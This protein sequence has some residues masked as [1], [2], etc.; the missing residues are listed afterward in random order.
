MTASP[1]ALNAFERVLLWS[2]VAIG[3]LVIAIRVATALFLYFSR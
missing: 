3:T 2:A 1:S